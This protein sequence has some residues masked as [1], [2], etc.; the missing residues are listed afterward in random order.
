MKY[1][2]PNLRDLYE[3][4]RKADKADDGMY[5]PEGMG[6]FRILIDEK[7]QEVKLG[8]VNQNGD[9][10]CA[11]SVLFGLI[12]SGSVGM[13]VAGD[14]DQSDVIHV[15]TTTSVWDIASC[16]SDGCDATYQHVRKLQGFLLDVLCPFVKAQEPPEIP[17]E[18]PIGEDFRKLTAGKLAERKAM[19]KQLCVRQSNDQ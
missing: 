2:R 6:D 11:M 17:T 9:F 16:Y 14:Q 8:Y 1:K 15:N 18:D 12:E 13:E 10:D 5:T 7:C 3:Y 19:Y 4:C